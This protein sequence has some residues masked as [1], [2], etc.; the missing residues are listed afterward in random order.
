LGVTFRDGKIAAIEAV[1]DSD[2]L[3]EMNFTLVES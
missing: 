1:A 2:R 3:A